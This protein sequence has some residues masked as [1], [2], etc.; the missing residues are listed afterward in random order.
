MALLVKQTGKKTKIIY[1]EVLPVVRLPFYA[2][3]ASMYSIG[4]IKFL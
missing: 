1:K 3:I 4:C 2:A